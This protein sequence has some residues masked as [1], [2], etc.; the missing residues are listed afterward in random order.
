[1][2]LQNSFQAFKQ[3]LFEQGVFIIIIIWETNQS[4]VY[5]LLLYI[6]GIYNE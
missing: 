1:M 5:K 6:I 2:Y 4:S 3:M